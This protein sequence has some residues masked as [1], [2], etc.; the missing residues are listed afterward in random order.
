[1]DE[2]KQKAAIP[3]FASWI[4]AYQVPGGAGLNRRLREAIAALQATDGGT[5]RS[6]HAGW[7]SQSD[8]FELA[9]P[10]FRELCVHLRE[11]LTKSVRRF[12]KDFDL[13]RHR[14]KLDGWVN[15]NPQNGFNAPHDHASNHLSGVYYVACPISRRDHGAA[16]EFLNPALTFEAPFALGRKMYPK[17]MLVRPGEGEMLVFPS[18]LWH[19][20]HP[21][22]ARDERISIAFNM[23][24]L[25]KEMS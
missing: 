25:E 10:S 12:W 8:I 23:T 9:D 22:M 18:H 6:N 16:I 3:A 2:L 7:H 17:R 14:H 1:M 15:V 11:G 21:N 24:V 13:A 19:W 20:V 4:D 5:E